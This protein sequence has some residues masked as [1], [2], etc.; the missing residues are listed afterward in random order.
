MRF[1]IASFDSIMECNNNI[2][3]YMHQPWWKCVFL[4]GG[5]VHEMKY[6]GGEA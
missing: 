6:G 2:S 4:F 1:T 5:I 3:S